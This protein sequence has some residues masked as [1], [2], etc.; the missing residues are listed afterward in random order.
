MGAT[1]Q[2]LQAQPKMLNKIVGTSNNQSKQKF[3]QKNMFST[4]KCKGA[5]NFYWGYPK[6]FAGSSQ[7]P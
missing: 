4:L 5:K 1:Q 7:Y 3:S 2:N 6:E